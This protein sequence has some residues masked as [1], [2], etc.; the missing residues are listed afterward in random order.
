MKPTPPALAEVPHGAQ[1]ERRHPAVRP[2]KADP[3]AHDDARID[4]P[5][6]LKTTHANAIGPDLKQKPQ[7]VEDLLCEAEVCT[8]FGPS[9]AGKTTLAIHLAICVALGID[10]LDKRTRQGAVVYLAAE[11]PGNVARRIAGA[12][13][14]FGI[15]HMPLLVAGEAID[16]FDGLADMA[17]VVDC[18]KYFEAQSGERVKLIVIDT[19]ARCCG[20]GDENSTKD[21]TVVMRT[22]TCIAEATGA[23]VL[24]IHH[25]GVADAS[26]SRGSSVIYSNADDE[27]VCEYNPTIDTRML[28]VKKQRELGTEH[29][30]LAARFVRVEVGI[31]E[32]GK[33][34]TVPIVEPADMPADT[35][36]CKRMGEVE[37]AV[38]EFLAERKVGIKKSAV[39]AH[40][41]GRYEKGPIYRAMKRLVT[42]HAI[43]EAAGMVCIAEAAK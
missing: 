18:V 32:W 23:A 21:M 37:G 42:A 2:T 40:F 29:E 36:I 24:V 19:L 7:V 41:K 43:H 6:P 9:Y 33:S 35:T 12:K 30:K 13:K 38:I 27:I 5:P 34:V 25:T 16:L 11:A 4:E 28:T 26:R 31:D 10:F 8:W 22:L 39:V 3:A 20:S 17:R 15:D 1:T 14:H